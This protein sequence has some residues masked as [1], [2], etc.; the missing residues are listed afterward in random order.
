MSLELIATKLELNNGLLTGKMRG[1]NNKGDEKVNRIKANWDLANYSDIYVY[2]DSY[3]DK[4]MMALATKSFYK[5]F[6]KA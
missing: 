1:K 4:P 3:A 6:R 5:P 2:G